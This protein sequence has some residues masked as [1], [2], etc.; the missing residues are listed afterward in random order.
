[1]GLLLLFCV[2]TTYLYSLRC[3]P[4]PWK[5]GEKGCRAPISGISPKKKTGFTML[6]NAKSGW[7]QQPVSLNHLLDRNDAI[8][9]WQR[10]GKLF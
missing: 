8:G 9:D 1:M 4:V 3:K 10:K 6:F 5:T 2:I 7:D